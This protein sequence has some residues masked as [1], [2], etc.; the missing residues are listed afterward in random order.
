[1]VAVGGAVSDIGS[2]VGSKI[3]GSLDNVVGDITSK[4]GSNIG[5]TAGD[6]SSRIGK[7]I[8]SNT[9][10]LAGKVGG[11][12]D[13][14]G[15]VGGDVGGDVGSGIAKKSGNMFKTFT[16]GIVAVSVITGGVF[17]G[18]YLKRT[19]DDVDKINNADISI[20]KIE[21][22]STIIMF[23]PFTSQAVITYSDP[24]NEIGENLGPA[25]TVTVTGS[26]SEP[27]ID[28]T[29]KLVSAQLGKIVID[30]KSPITKIGDIGKLK[31]HTNMTN[32]VTKDLNNPIN[33]FLNSMKNIFG[34]P[35]KIITGI[36]IVIICIV[37][38]FSI[39]SIIKMIRGGGIKKN[40]KSL[41][42]G[43]KNK[44]K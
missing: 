21:D 43:Y 35:T 39:P 31:F 36:V 5:D 14:L 6:V 24:K 27:N 38:L 28:G 34:D 40:Y 22:N 32:Q 41:K 18:M 33:T 23:I 9:D 2:K 19:S 8:I 37:A 25:D 7:D 44:I 29:Y 20:T 1:M 3:A 16:K 11:N 10:S 12:A 15:K 17:A 26:N 4:I 42:N 13:S 30:I